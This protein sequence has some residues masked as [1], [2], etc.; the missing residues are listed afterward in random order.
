MNTEA[1]RADAALFIWKLLA[2][3]KESP[4]LLSKY[5]QKY[6][7]RPGASSPV[8]DV[9]L[10]SPYFDAV[11]GC[12]EMEIMNLPDG[13]NFMPDDPVSGAMFY[14]ALAAALNR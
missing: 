1:H 5:T 4:A 14:Q 6:S 3:R 7:G 13:K 9:P 11:L 12:V 8:P 10:G 2:S